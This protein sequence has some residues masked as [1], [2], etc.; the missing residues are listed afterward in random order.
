M[1]PM[2]M[3]HLTLPAIERPTDAKH[4][5][6]IATSPETAHRN[7]RGFQPSEGSAK[8]QPIEPIRHRWVLPRIGELV[9]VV[10]E[11]TALPWRDHPGRVVDKRGG[12][13]RIGSNGKPLPPAIVQYQ[14]TGYGS[15]YDW[16]LLEPYGEPY[17]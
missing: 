9:W 6:E 16:F 5:R 13:P 14:V 1:N 10:D 4:A 12:T 17:P 3:T 2:R 11:R 15:W 8:C 7:L